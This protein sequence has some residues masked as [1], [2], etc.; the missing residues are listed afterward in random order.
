MTT[1]MTTGGPTRT[2]VRWRRVLLI[3]LAIAV[4][5]EVGVRALDSRLPPATGWPGYEYAVHEEQ[6]AALGGDPDLLVIGD[7]SAAV[8]IRPDELVEDGVASS[9]YNYW[10]GGAPMRSLELHASEVLLP[11]TTP[12]TV[13]VAVTMRNFNE[14]P[15]Q[16][17]HLA[18]L[19]ASSAFRRVTGRR[20]WLDHLDDRLQAGSAVFRHREIL[21][22]PLGLVRALRS[23]GLPDR[24]ASDGHISDR[25][26]DRLADEAA[27]HRRAEREALAD[28]AVSPREV[29]ALDDLLTELRRR[30]TQVVV[31]SLPVAAAFVELADGGTQDYLRFMSAVRATGRA[32]GVEVLDTMEQPWPD[33][34]FG[35]VNHLNDRGAARLRPI[36]ADAIQRRSEA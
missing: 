8:A 33:E 1:T 28:F 18:A 30:G 11:R 13:V 5:A 20:S 12:R 6:L 22:D 19:R 14:A 16:E 7:S 31:V 25:G 29:G 34:L 10:L 32:N 3:A 26:G 9:G 2:R 17:S 15:S 35:D 4:L 27:G 24:L 23:P 36:L 21:R